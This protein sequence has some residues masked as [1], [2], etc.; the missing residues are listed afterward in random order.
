MPDHDH[1]DPASTA[2]H[3]PDTAERPGETVGELYDRL[4]PGQWVEAYGVRIQ[5]WPTE[6][7]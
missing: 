3:D 5:R 6:E 7:D 1:T 2:I 4:P